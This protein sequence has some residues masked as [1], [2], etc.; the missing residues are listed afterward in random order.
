MATDGP[1]PD[2][3]DDEIYRNGTEVCIVASISSNRM[4]N[5]IKLIREFTQERVDWYYVGG[6][7]IVKVL[8]DVESVKYAILAKLKELKRLVQESTGPGYEDYFPFQ[9]LV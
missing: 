3:C 8:G 2:P 9:W 4:E 1:D 7:A 6:R 5:F